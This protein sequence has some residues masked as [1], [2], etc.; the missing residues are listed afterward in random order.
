MSRSRVRTA[1]DEDPSVVAA[2]RS[3]SR[4]RQ[5]AAHN[6][7]DAPAPSGRGG[8]GNVVRSASRDPAGEAA[9]M[10]ALDEEDEQVKEKYRQLHKDDQQTAGRG[11]FG[12]V[13]HLH[14]NN[15]NAAKE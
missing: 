2:A 8:A 6:G 5:R 10:M 11:G 1:Q 15:N 13:P 4:S 14:H 3:R 7:H 12:N 9:K